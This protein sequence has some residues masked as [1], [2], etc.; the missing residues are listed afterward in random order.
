MK[1][2]PTT[3]LSEVHMLFITLRLQEVI[4]S[5]QGK[6][7]G[8]ISRDKMKRVIGVKQHFVHIR[9]QLQHY[10]LKYFW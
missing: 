6:L 5:E 3:P 9:K 4:V 1:V 7:Q 10:K 8:M 2:L